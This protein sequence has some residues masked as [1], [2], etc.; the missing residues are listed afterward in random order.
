MCYWRY[1]IPSVV[2]IC[3]GLFFLWFQTMAVFL[4]VATFVGF[5]IAYMFF[6]S[7]LIQEKFEKSREKSGLVEL[8]NQAGFRQVTIYMAKKANWLKE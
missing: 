4:V 8:R 6:V 5:G 2:S 7:K 1:Y 3:L